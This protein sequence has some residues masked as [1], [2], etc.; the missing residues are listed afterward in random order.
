MQ[1]L[2]T[3]TQSG[4]GRHILE[5]LGGYSWNR[6]ILTE[7]KDHFLNAGVDVIIHS[8][9]NSQKEIDSANIGQYITDN[10]LLTETLLHIPHQK[11]IYISTVDVYLNQCDFTHIE[12]EIIDLNDMKKIKGIYGLTKLMSESLVKQKGK[13]FLI[14][15]SVTP[16]GIYSRKNT[17]M[18]ILQ[19]DPCRVYLT[20]SSRYNCVLYEDFS[21]FISF[22]IQNKI[23]GIF[24]VASSE[25]ISLR[26]IVELLGKEVIYGNYH[27]DVGYL[28]NQKIAAV[29]PV[30]KK[31]SRE[32][33]LQFFSNWNRA[34]IV[35]V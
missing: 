16:L 27:Y 24:N 19:D 32:V 33:I 2:T 22:S 4:L 17:I 10:L 14:L 20:P 7:E 21:D 25:T 13:N 5:V 1:L 28:S 34:N 26:E 29:F 15:R 9:F 30:L 18:K 3:G 23:I 11:F 35:E 8:A 6:D 12:D 31:T